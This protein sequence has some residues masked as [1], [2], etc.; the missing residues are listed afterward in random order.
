[1]SKLARIGRII[2]GLWGL[3]IYVTVIGSALWPHSAWVTGL[4]IVIFTPI[5]LIAPYLAFVLIYEGIT[6]K[7]LWPRHA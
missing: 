3:A 1:M 6:G 4:L 2:F 5:A 7:R